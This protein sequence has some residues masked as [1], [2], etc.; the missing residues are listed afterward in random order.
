YKQQ[1]LHDDVLIVAERTMETSNE[2]INLWVSSLESI[3]EDKQLPHFCCRRA[4]SLLNDSKKTKHSEINKSTR[5]VHE[6][7]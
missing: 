6:T 3:S 7:P 5:Q 1:I 2:Y 4:K